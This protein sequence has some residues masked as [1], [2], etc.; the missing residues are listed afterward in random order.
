MTDFT[1]L[2]NKISPYISLTRLNR[3]IGIYLLLWPTLWVLW[4]VTEGLPNI[5]ILFIFILG[6]VLMRSAGCAIN[7]YADRN[8][9]GQ[10]ERTK[11]R[12]IVSGLL[13]SKQAL[14][15]AA[16]LAVLAFVLVLFLNTQTI[17]MSSV[18]LILAIIYP[19][20]KRYTYLP[21]LFLGMAFAWATP[22]VYSAL[23]VDFSPITWLLYLASVV[24]ALGYDTL[25]AMADR[26]E[27]LK[28]GVKSSAILFGENGLKMVVTF[29]VVVLLILFLVGQQL[30]LSYWFYLGLVGAAINVN[31]QIWVAKN[32]EPEKCIQAFLQNHYFGM[33]IFIGLFIH[34][35]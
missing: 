28:I 35:L 3:P 25:Y 12:P 5:K 21:Q 6:T 2:S 16:S 20:M 19:F 13:S 23:E 1:K 7:D 26:D 29:H 30:H 18:A 17:Y 15:T 11:S 24:W 10:V 31:H 32:C 8:V 22:M 4:I 27:D 33:S 34:Y 9:D 14:I